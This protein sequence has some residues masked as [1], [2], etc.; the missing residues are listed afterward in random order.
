MKTYYIIKAYATRY[1]GGENI[2]R[3]HYF[4]KSNKLIGYITESGVQRYSKDDIRDHG[5]RSYRKAL[6]AGWALKDEDR[7]DGWTVVITIIAEVA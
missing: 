2:E 1:I 4:G 6:E 7:S 3:F 5:Y